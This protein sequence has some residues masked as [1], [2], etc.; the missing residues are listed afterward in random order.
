ML[1]IMLAQ[2]I[3]VYLQGW[4]GWGGWW[5]CKRGKGGRVAKL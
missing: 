1:T 2:S 5:G 3:K 4:L